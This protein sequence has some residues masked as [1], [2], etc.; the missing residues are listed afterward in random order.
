MMIMAPKSMKLISAV[1]ASYAKHADGKSHSGGEVGFES[2]TWCY[3]AC[4]V[5]SQW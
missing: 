5:S 3:F 1:D 2:D 4:Q